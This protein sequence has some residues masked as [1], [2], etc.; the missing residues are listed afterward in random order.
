MVLNPTELKLSTSMERLL[1]QNRFD[2]R[3]DSQFEAT[4][5][6]CASSERPEQESPGSKTI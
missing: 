1:R 3:I 5:R 4:M 6:A 2:V